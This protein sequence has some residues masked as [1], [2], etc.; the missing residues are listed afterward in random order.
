M[1][2]YGGLVMESGPVGLFTAGIAGGIPGKNKTAAKTQ[3]PGHP[4]TQA[5]L[6][7]S[8]HFG[9]H[10]SQVRLL[11]IPGKVTD[12]SSPPPGCPFAPRCAKAL[13]ECSAAIP[14]LTIAAE[15]HEIRCVLSIQTESN[16]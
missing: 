14:P 7:A 16:T 15:S 13:P 9:T 11:T 3:G 4:Y 2:M 6:A 12:P 1:V 8:P 10:Y 5:L